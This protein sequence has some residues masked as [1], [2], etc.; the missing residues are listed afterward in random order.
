M[1]SDLK[2]QLS[3]LSMYERAILMFCLRAYFKS[4]NY[5]NELPLGEM[6]P[7]MAAIFDVNPDVTIFA[8]LSGLQMSAA[9]G[10]QLPVKVFVSM[11]YEQQGQRLV[12]VLNKQADLAGL[13]KIVDN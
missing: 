6:L 1:D 5:K 4:G 8:K 12:T 11:T 13:L 7:D 3:T 9:T 10:P 2:K